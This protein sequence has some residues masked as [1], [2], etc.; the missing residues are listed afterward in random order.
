M[1]QR[2]P[3]ILGGN[4][5]KLAIFGPNCSSGIAFTKL[6]ERWETSWDNNLK[7]ARMADEAE[8][9]GSRAFR[10]TTPL[11]AEANTNEAKPFLRGKSDTF[12]Q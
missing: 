2:N 8:I 5:F 7:L 6:P 11:I 9:W 12:A 4:L 1:S 3:G 10:S